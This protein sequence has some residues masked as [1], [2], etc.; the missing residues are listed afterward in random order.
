VEAQVIGGG[1]TLNVL[2]GLN[3]TT[4]ILL[5]MAVIIPY[6]VWGGFQSVVYTDCVQSIIMIF[7]LVVT[8]IAG[9]IY[10]AKRS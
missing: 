5:T 3:P 4:G 10:I 2:F 7:T 1:K 9:I 6:T 8:P